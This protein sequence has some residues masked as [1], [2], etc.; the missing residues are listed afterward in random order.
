MEAIFQI[1]KELG[2]LRARIETLE[3]TKRK[4]GC[5]GRQRALTEAE[6]TDTQR[7]SLAILRANHGKIV[8]A[9]NTA[10]ESVGVKAALKENLVV[11]GYTVMTVEEHLRRRGFSDRPTCCICCPDGS[12]CCDDYGCGSCSC[13]N[14][15][16]FEG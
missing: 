1:G 10:L 4:C 15:R 12:Y 7:Q 14:P 9:F 6:L 11:A 13:V 16:V 3:T 8:E 5:D 2:E